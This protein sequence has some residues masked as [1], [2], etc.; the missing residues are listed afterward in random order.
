MLHVDASPFYGSTDATLPLPQFLSLLS[1]GG[2]LSGGAIHTFAP[3]APLPA[4]LLPF[5]R[6][7]MVDLCPRVLL[8]QGALSSLLVASDAARYLTF[9]RVDRCFVGCGGSQQ[10]LRVPASKADVFSDG[11]L[12]LLEKRAVM[13]FLQAATDGVAWAG[14]GGEG[15]AAGNGGGGDA[16]GVAQLN[17]AALG[18]ARSLLRPQNKAPSR[19]DEGAF[20]GAPFG[21]LLAEMGLSGRAG[22]MVRGALAL[23]GCGGAPW[24]AVGGAVGMA[25]SRSYLAALARFGGSAFL[26]YEY[27]SGTLCE[28]FC[29][30]A[31][32]HGGIYVL[33]GAPQGWRAEG[34]GLAAALPE[35]GEVRARAALLPPRRAAGA[36]CSLVVCLALLR[37]AGTWEE[38]GG[39]A[40]AEGA[41]PP[42]FVSSFHVA[43]PPA[44]PSRP[45]SAAA[46]RLGHPARMAPPGFATLAV[47]A[48]V[49]QGEEEGAAASLAEEAR[50]L[51]AWDGGGAGEAP[52]RLLWH[53]AYAV[54]CGSGAD[55]DAPPLPAG[56]WEAT[57]A[58]GG[59]WGGCTVVG[60][61]VVGAAEGLFRGLFPGAP[62]F[63]P[64][65]AAPPHEECGGQ[66]E[67]AAEEAAHAAGADAGADAGAGEGAAAPPQPPP[68]A[69]PAAPA[70]APAELDLAQALALLR[71]EPLPDFL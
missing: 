62:F 39:G 38:E 25:R 48:E 40:D 71:E 26:S 21:D 34:G 51:A 15:G 12:G 69:A 65:E 60:E 2:A 11:A 59:V 8:A 23:E 3:P 55:G 35:H 45:F 20:A 19:V 64:F 56:V 17:E 1:S 22:A 66:G 57:A 31:A 44:P 61:D 37:A 7:V 33:G 10:L 18:A 67:G 53:V 16:G 29:R 58:P 32:V 52:L 63:Q 54:R 30:L 70:E 27:G 36:R 41:A 42:P 14:G 68:P 43:L 6:H 13:R 5:A 4:S 49:G 24:G 47:Y 28:A 9:R 50:T 46:L